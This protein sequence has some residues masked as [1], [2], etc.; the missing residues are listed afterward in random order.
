MSYIACLILLQKMSETNIFCKIIKEQRFFTYRF[1]LNNKK[2][3]T[4]V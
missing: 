2:L 3:L 4:F 1:A